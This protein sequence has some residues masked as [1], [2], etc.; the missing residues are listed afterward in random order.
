MAGTGDLDIM[1]L[2]R[3]QRSKAGPSASSLNYGSQVAVHSALGLLFLGGG[4][5]TL[6]TSKEAIAALVCAFFPKFPLHS[7]DNRWDI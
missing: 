4:R 7:N 5:Y 2:C 1:R 3:Y 6:C